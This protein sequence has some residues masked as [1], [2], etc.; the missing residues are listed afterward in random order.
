MSCGEDYYF[1]KID[2]YAIGD[3]SDN[4]YSVYP[5]ISKD[6]KSSDKKKEQ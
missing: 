6:K 4:Q 1:N 3:N 2:E 5:I